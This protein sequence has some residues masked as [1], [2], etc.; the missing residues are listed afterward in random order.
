MNLHQETTSR[1]FWQRFFFSRML[2]GKNH[3]HK[4]AYIGVM[5]A[6]CVAAN[7]LEIKL[8]NVQF[9]LTI[10]ISAFAGIALGGVAGFCACFLGDLF[11]FLI[12]PFGE[13]SPWIGIST[14]LMALIV[15]WLI[16]LP[17][18]VEKW[19]RVK[20]AV[21]CVLIFFVCTAGITT[22]YLN[23]VWNPTM[24]YWQYLTYRLL[25]QG[26]IY[27]SLVNSVIVIFG[28]PFILKIKTLRIFP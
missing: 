21:G 26:Q 7:M 27:N 20:L 8:G 4:I 15:A 3:S 2:M 22:I 19:L 6:F 24:T 5:T 10:C 25:V 14:A 18:N 16:Y 11:G 17:T 9:S 12:H 1:P 13:Y 23:V 28:L